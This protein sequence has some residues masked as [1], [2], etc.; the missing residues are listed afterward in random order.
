M[1]GPLLLAAGVAGA[2]R[3]PNSASAWGGVRHRRCARVCLPAR[4]AR[5]SPAMRSRDR[6]RCAPGA[7]PSSPRQRRGPGDPPRVRGGSGD[8][9]SLCTFCRGRHGGVGPRRREAALSPSPVG[10]RRAVRPDVA[11]GGRGG[12]I[13]ARRRRGGSRAHGNA[14]RAPVHRGRMRGR[15]RPLR[16]GSSRRRRA[17]AVRH[18]SRPPVRRR[19]AVDG[20]EDGLA[21]ASSRRRDRRLGNGARRRRRLSADGGPPA[22]PSTP[23]P[24]MVLAW[25]LAQGA[26]LAVGFGRAVRIEGLA[27]LS[28][29][30][31]AEASR[32]AS[33]RLPPGGTAQGIEVVHSTTLS[34]RN[35]RDLAH[36]VR[37]DSWTLPTMNRVQA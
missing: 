34:A 9:A 29:A 7:R 22:G 11:H 14:C 25:L 23:H 27:E 10:R 26:Q 24:A 37:T 20:V 2:L 32:R 3:I 13:Q 35:S 4:S 15:A 1:L 19:R 28:R 30:D 16:R 36:R 12:S 6:R 31:A 17:I 8:A 33:S 21:V 5:R 18:R